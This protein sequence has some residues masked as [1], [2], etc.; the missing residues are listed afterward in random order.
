MDLSNNSLIGIQAINVTFSKSDR[1]VR[2]L[3]HVEAVETG[4]KSVESV[5]MSS[6]S[7]VHI[8]RSRDD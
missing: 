7:V 4:G 2:K 5:K 8:E 6:K 3:D 1:T